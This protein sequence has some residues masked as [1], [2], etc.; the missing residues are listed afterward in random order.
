VI[1]FDADPNLGFGSTTIAENQ[2]VSNDG[3]ML[4][5]LVSF[6]PGN[7]RKRLGCTTCGAD[8]YIAVLLIGQT[9]V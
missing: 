2:L 3:K 9:V 4:A 8:F 1:D 5:R 6:P 7:W